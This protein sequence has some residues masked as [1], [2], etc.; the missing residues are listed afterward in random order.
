M[1]S[2]HVHPSLGLMWNTTPPR[3]VTSQD[4]ARG[5]LRN[6]DPTLAPNGNP[7]YYVSTIQGFKAFCTAFENS[8]P[9]ES[10]AARA[11]FINNGMTSVSGIRRRTPRPS[12]SR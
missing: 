9:A 8:N 5:I 1:A 4:F 12:S 10:P 11:T 7:G 3:P 2:L 6:C